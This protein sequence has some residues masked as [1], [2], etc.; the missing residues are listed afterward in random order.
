MVKIKIVNRLTSLSADAS[1]VN[2][3]G[4]IRE[5]ESV[6]ASWQGPDTHFIHNFQLERVLGE[7]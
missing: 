5:A 2:L 3:A 4:W 6:G 1:T 7:R